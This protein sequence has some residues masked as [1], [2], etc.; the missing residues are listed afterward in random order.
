MPD[1]SVTTTFFA[2]EKQ[3]VAALARLEQKYEDLENKV[4]HMAQSHHG[5]SHG[6]IHELGELATAAAGIAVGYITAEKLL[7][8]MAES[9]REYAKET[10]AAAKSVDSLNR[11]L[12]VR[13]VG[14]GEQGKEATEA[15][16]E[17]ANRAALPHDTANALF[18]D[19]KEHG[20][21]QDDLLK[22][23]PQ[24]AAA[25]KVTSE[26]KGGMVSGQDFANALEKSLDRAAPKTGVAMARAAK[27]L[28]AAVRGTQMSV[29]DVGALSE[30][31]ETSKAG[32]GGLQNPKH[33]Q[34]LSMMG[35]KFE[36]IDMQGED[37]ATVIDR[38]RVGLQRV[39][40]HDR[41]SVLKLLTGDAGM[42]RRVLSGMGGMAAN[43]DIYDAAVKTSTSGI[44]A[45]S[46]RLA[47]EK[48]ERLAA[49]GGNF[50]NLAETAEQ[51]HQAR[52]SS[53]WLA[54]FRKSIAN[55]FRIFGD[56]MG[57]RM[58]YGMTGTRPEDQINVDT[59]KARAAEKESGFTSDQ[60]DEMIGLQ[61]EQNELLKEI[62]NGKKRPA[63]GKG[64]E[65]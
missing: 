46:Q 8:G 63:R 19:I 16:H 10:D 30:I 47:N 55:T 5:H 3:A 17:A 26:A 54:G 21:K 62:A 24:L 31:F 4:K 6:M 1:N 37:F 51:M 40:E 35:M 34:A 41:M 9:T 58:G 61:R 15:I 32:K 29:S 44:A 39:K 60:A 59:I 53:P 20:I 18:G 48:E 65:E 13:A 28:F 43:R 38:L 42:A 45:G 11:A 25:F 22:N 14:F 52:G 12:A 57:I 7:E 64:A 49:Q 23:F 36:D 2:D 33:Q 56:D 50:E 27:D